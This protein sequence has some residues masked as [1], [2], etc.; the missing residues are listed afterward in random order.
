MEPV[1]RKSPLAREYEFWVIAE[2][3]GD[4]MFTL[5]ICTGKSHFLFM[6]EEQILKIKTAGKICTIKTIARRCSVKMFH[7]VENRRVY[8]FI[9]I[10]N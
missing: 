3:V 5:R 6:P 9:T 7:R 10:F 1:D 2:D 4:V 8:V